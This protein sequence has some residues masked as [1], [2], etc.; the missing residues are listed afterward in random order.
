MDPH[1][2]SEPGRI[3]EYLP[4]QRSHLA[5]DVTQFRLAN[6][7]ILYH[8]HPNHC[9]TV[10]PVM[11][12]SSS[13]G[14]QLVRTSRPRRTRLSSFVGKNAAKPS[15]VT[16]YVSEGS[17]LRSIP[18]C[19]TGTMEGNLNT[20][21]SRILS[22]SYVDIGSCITK[23]RIPHEKNPYAAFLQEPG[24]HSLCIYRRG[25]PDTSKKVSSEDICRKIIIAHAFMHIQ[26]RLT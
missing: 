11:I 13:T 2:D 1:V 14:M 19:Q 15:L 26:K 12:Y 20:D 10:G 7:M 16:E 18:M 6:S 4:E 8:H 25:S 17:N 21:I 23:G 9:Q 5:L 24:V 22:A 3:E